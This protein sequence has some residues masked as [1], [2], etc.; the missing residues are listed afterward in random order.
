MSYLSNGLVAQ[1]HGAVK[2]QIVQ[3]DD[4]FRIQRGANPY[5]IKGAGGTGQLEKLRDYGG[6]S[7]RTW[8]TKDAGTILDEAHR[9]GLTV[10]LGL[11]MGVERHGFDYNDTKAVAEQLQRVR[12]EVEQYKDHPALLAWGIGNELNLHYS[13][14]KVWDAVN[15]V[16][17][18]IKQLDNNHLVTT[19]L[20]G[21]NKK[22]IDL[23]KTKCS[24]LD[25]IAVQVY[26]GLASVPQ[27]LKT[28]GWDKAYMVTEWGP[29]GHW[30]SL[31]TPWKASIEESSSEKAAVYKAR[32]EASIAKDNHCVG[33]YVFLWGQKQERTP[34]W[35]GLFTEKGEESEV[36]DVMQYLWKGTW[37]KNRAP[38]LDAALLD[39][40][41]ATDFIYLQ[42]DQK[43]PLSLVVNDPDNDDLQTR[44]ELLPESTDLKEGGDRESR[45]KALQGHVQALSH[46]QAELTT[47]H[48]GGAYRLF[49]Y[50]SDGHNHVATAN[51]PF[52]VQ[53]DHPTD[54]SP[55]PTNYAFSNTPS[56]ADEFNY[57]GLP[58]QSKWSYDV[59]SKHQGWG[60]NEL[61]YYTEAN[62]ANVLVKNGVLQITARK[63]QKGGM[64]YT[65][66]R[67]VSKGK[68]DFLYGRFEA[69]AKLPTG[70]G[71]WPAIWMLPTTWTYGGWPS[72]GEIDIM[73]HVGYDQ[74]VVHVSVHTKA[75]HHSINTQKTATK[76]IAHASQEFHTYRV[77][78]TPEYIKGFIDDLEIFHFTNEKTGF[79]VW[80]F[81]QKFHWLINLAIGGNWGGSQ[82]VSDDIF[83]AKLEVDYVRVYDL[84]P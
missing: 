25:L 61:Q 24:A 39:N 56:W 23:I 77:D 11:Q 12:R 41:K 30:E 82:G 74:D 4:G 80:P 1:P 60:N 53:N 42:P 38:H 31:Q 68:G 8:S 26:G 66:A 46:Q 43:Y 73:E 17:I 10:T 7:V 40:K 64:N 78:W 15:E 72:S 32:Y 47:P 34:T 9:L 6:N 57:N 81:D 70:R 49:V 50:V 79:E 22:E 14:P 5:F 65:S 62:T 21:I 69:R 83:P 36:I 28:A 67:L 48:T 27:Q 52:F 44:W 3:T 35:Y 63:E 75:Y 45:P 37:P 29:T 2:T 20:A 33:S 59:G 76:K 58:D 18:M 16:A 19:M 84:L 71:T 51:I 54:Q 55:T 13:N